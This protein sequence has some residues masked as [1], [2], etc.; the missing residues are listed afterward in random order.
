MN[1]DEIALD[2]Q[3]A[4]ETL[5]A[6]ASAALRERVTVGG[7]LS[8]A[9]LE[10]EQHAVH[11]LSWLATYVEAIKELQA[12][13]ARMR[14]EG[15][16]GKTEE[17]LTRI[18]LGEYLAQMFSGIAM[19]QGEIVRLEDFGLVD[20]QI[21]PLKQGAVAE[22]IAQGNTVQNR[23]RLAALIA[24]APAGAIGDPGLDETLEAMRAEM[25]RF[26]EA[27]V[28]PFA[29]DWHRKNEYIPLEVIQGLSDMGVFGLTIPEAFGGLGLG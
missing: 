23:A 2:G 10:A 11:G 5:L 27:E 18:G 8:A 20:E 7:K 6:R 13:A 19:N 1:L 28:V 16:F 24:E 21:A 17:L 14:G 4:A 22:L 25:R 12:Y 26:A 29:Q 3:H 9:K 15:R